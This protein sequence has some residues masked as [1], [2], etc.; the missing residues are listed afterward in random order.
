MQV[1]TNLK[2]TAQKKIVAMLEIRKVF[3]NNF[4]KKASY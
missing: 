2:N 4:K 1:S 3:A